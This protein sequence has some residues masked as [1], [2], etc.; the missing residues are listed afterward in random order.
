MIVN[1]AHSGCIEDPTI[2]HQLYGRT[3]G[4]CQEHDWL[5]LCRHLV[6]QGEGCLLCFLMPG[7]WDLT[8]PS[9][10]IEIVS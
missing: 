1:C 5:Y 2:F 6:F 7:F 3:F 9:D 4:F 8:V 10:F